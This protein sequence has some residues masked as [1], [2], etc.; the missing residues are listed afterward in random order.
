MAMVRNAMSFLAAAFLLITVTKATTH[1]VGD[2]LG[3][4]TNVDYKAWASKNPIKA[5]D[6][7][8]KLGSRPLD[9]QWLNGFNSSH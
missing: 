5:G 1:I 3:W 7:L 2:K 8:G 9:A 6:T 4:S